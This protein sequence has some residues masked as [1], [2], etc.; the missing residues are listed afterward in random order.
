MKIKKACEATNL[1][2]RAIRLYLSKGLITPG[3]SNGILDFSAED[4]QHLRDIAVLRQF[5]FTIEQIAGMV[6]DAGEIPE[7]LRARIADA[8][9]ERDRV[10]EVSEVLG[11]L[12]AGKCGSIH[13]LADQ[14]RERR[15]H[16]PGLYFFQFDEITG[17]ER[18]RQRQTATRELSIMEKRTR[19]RQW[20]VRMIILVLA[21]CV[22]VGVYLGQTRVEGFISLSPMTVIEVY[23]RVLMIEDMRATVRTGNEATIEALGRDTM[24]VPYSAYGSPLEAGMTLENGCQLT[25]KLTNLD[26]LRM[27]INPLQTMQTRSDDINDAWMRYILQ[28]L[29]AQDYEEQTKLVVRDYTGL[30]PLFREREP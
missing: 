21:V 5:D 1:T 26:L 11:G 8:Q 6:G 10:N 12:D 24:T 19:L 30:Q 17:E 18:Q 16:S 20:L 2:E 27:G 4:I 9:V 25:V 7:L 28:T 23:D 3:S 29:F 22:V 14:I 13:A 15:M